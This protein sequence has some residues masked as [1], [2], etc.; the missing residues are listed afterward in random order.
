MEITKAIIT[1]GGR[2][3]RFLPAVKAYQKEMIPVMNKPQL[4]WIIEEAVE[5]GIKQIA[6][7]NREGVDTFSRYWADDDKLMKFL[8]ETGKSSL[9]DSLVDLKNKVEI[10]MF[11]QKESDPYGN[12]TPFLLTKDW[13]DGEP[14]AAMWGDD[15]MVRMDKTKPTVLVQ[16][17][18]Y[19][20]RYNPAAVMSVFEAP[21]GSIPKGGR[22][23]Y[24]SEMES[25][26]PYHAKRVIEKPSI[27]E[28][29]S[30][31]ENSCR[32]ILGPEVFIEL[33]QR[34][35]GMGGEI[36]LVDSVNR[37][38]EK[39]LLVIAHPWEGFKVVPCGDPIHWLQGNLLVALYSGEFDSEK[40][41]LIEFIK[42]LH[43]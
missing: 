2:G 28:A 14:I 6:I 25:E 35:K 21:I 17:M 13:T 30:Q 8:E 24:F 41:E 7:V 22:Y 26:I 27:E 39:G 20:E 38:M 9:M 29:P 16:M 36:W 1:A 32:F 4:Q 31:F 33:E 5:S 34:I 12:G 23:E 19:F 37:L 40:S 10:T 15:I 11:E 3:T 42:N 43:L 18:E